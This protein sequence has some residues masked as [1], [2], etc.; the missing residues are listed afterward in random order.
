[1]DGE[2]GFW[3]VLVH[4]RVFGAKR[5]PGTFLNKSD[6]WGR[7]KF[8]VVSGRGGLKGSGRKF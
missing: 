7:N 1:M 8:S 4:G 3:A 6:F 2:I 5:G